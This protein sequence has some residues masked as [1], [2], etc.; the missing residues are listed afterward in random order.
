MADILGKSSNIVFWTLYHALPFFL[1]HAVRI[2]VAASGYFP[3]KVTV[4]TAASGL[5]TWAVSTAPTIVS[6]L[7]S[8]GQVRETLTSSTETKA[9]EWKQ[10]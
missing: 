7:F 4:Q 9:P 3:N 2:V 10:E 6:D 5:L 8:S 1:S